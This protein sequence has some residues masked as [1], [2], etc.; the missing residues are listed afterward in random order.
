MEP[1]K[2]IRVYVAGTRGIPDIQGGVETHCQELYPRLAAL[3]CDVV[4][5]RRRPY[6]RDGA[7][8]MYRGVRIVDLPAPRVKTLEAAVHTML[9]VADA[10]RRGCDLIH[11]HA[12]G[13]GLM[14]GLARLLGLR[15][16]STNHGADYNRR[17]W[18]RFAR[19]VI[20]LGERISTLMSDGVI[21]IT[22]G[23]A[24]EMGRRYGRTDI[25]VIAN[26]VAAGNYAGGGCPSGILEKLGLTA[27]NYILGVGRLV[28]EK[29]FH[30]L[31]EAYGRLGTETGIKLVIAGKPDHESEYSRRLMT[32]AEENGVVMAGEVDKKTLN[33][34]Y[35][36]AALYVLPSYHEG[37][38]I[39]LL[40]A[41][42]AG[43]EIA[44]SAIPAN[45]LPQFD[46]NDFFAP[47]DIDGLTR[48]MRRKLAEGRD[49]RYDLSDYDWDRIA[50]RTLSLYRRVLR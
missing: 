44:L 43:V 21:A 15:T 20:R 9:C 4:V 35:R 32:I 36:G 33:D 49:R 29:G 37:L 42:G 23:I 48:V 28:E 11:I 26:G 30:D 17:K 12:I 16:V 45:R 40:E 10:R 19:A 31:I 7:P 38:S 6:R 13:P 46:D 3:G 14:T 50:R 18:G 34:L 24:A 47:G 27:G 5:A 2:R 41:M 1:E 22:P 39:S 8:D 25:E